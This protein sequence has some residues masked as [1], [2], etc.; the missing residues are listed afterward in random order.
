MLPKLPQ[1]NSGQMTLCKKWHTHAAKPAPPLEQCQLPSIISREGRHIFSWYCHYSFCLCNFLLN[2]VVDVLV[3]LIHPPTK[4]EELEYVFGLT[5]VFPS[6]F[7]ISHHVWSALRI[8]LSGEKRTSQKQL[9]GALHMLCL[10]DL[11]MTWSS[12]LPS[13]LPLIC[14]EFDLVPRNCD[15]NLLVATSHQG[16]PAATKP[17][18]QLGSLGSLCAAPSGS[19]HLSSLGKMATDKIRSLTSTQKQGK[20][21]VQTE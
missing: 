13:I 3:K 12:L 10:A 16:L 4:A 20:H 14:L 9:L 15:T 8:Y 6:L 19:T 5:E 2:E 18:Q 17:N 21:L 1:I 11:S 7:F